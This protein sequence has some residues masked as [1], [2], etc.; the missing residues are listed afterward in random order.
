MKQKVLEDIHY[1]MV[2]L[3]GGLG[4]CQGF[5]NTER[6]DLGPSSWHLNLFGIGFRL[7]QMRIIRRK[8]K[9]ATGPVGHDRKR[10]RVTE[11]WPFKD[12]L[13]MPETHC[14]DNLLGSNA[15]NALCARVAE[16]PP[17]VKLG[18]C[19]TGGKAFVDKIVLSR[20]LPG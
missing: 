1:K 6:F 17:V 2:L 7:V 16:S 18:R 12:F 10:K 8:R 4:G 14:T 3:I 11:R 5:K 19:W 13:R 9:K 15:R 20:Q